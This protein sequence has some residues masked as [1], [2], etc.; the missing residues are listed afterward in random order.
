MKKLLNTDLL[1][2]FSFLKSVKDNKFVEREIFSPGIY[3][4]G[5]E[6]LGYGSKR[7]SG[8]NIIA[9]GKREETFLKDSKSKLHLYIDNVLKWKPPVLILSK[10]ITIETRKAIVEIA[11]KY[12]VMILTT[13]IHVRD[14]AFQV[15]Q[16]LAQEFSPSKTVHAS[17]V[18]INGVGV[19]I[20][21]ESGIG[22][23]EAVLEL[24]S[25]GHQFV[26]D[27][28]IEIIFF[29]NSFVGRSAKLTKNFLEARGLGIIDIKY[30]FGAKTVK[31]Y[32][33]V[34]LVVELIDSEKKD[35]KFDR[36]GNEKHY[37]SILGGQLPLIQIP[38]SSGRNSSILIET[39]SHLLEYRQSG[40]DPIKVI[41][42][43]NDN[44]GK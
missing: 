3:R 39:A 6:F 11:N 7:I 15:G 32:H 36:I 34:D 10:N 14:I 9:W 35:V 40:K 1:K 21:G 33:R 19:L 38:V 16:F 37:F 24:L 8:S 29:G 13:K 23:S 2:E 25:R 17:L 20:Q 26:G 41:K 44:N 12:K 30:I 42:E 27:D 43:R 22:K 18:V 31:E 4:G 28:A 5:L